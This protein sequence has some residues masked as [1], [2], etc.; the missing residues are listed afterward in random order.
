MRFWIWPLAGLLSVSILFV[1]LAGDRGALAQPATA[2]AAP[3]PAAVTPP[4]DLNDPRAIEAG[5][6]HFHVTCSHYCHGGGGRGSGIRGPSLRNRNFDNAYL[7]ARISNG[8][9]P[10]PAFKSIYTPEQ[11]WTIIAYIQSLRD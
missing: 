2:P 4:I 6:E 10:M 8:Y 5:R 1:A 11:I 7:F 3:A 9:P